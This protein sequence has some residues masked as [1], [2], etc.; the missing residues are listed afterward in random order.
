L[1]YIYTTVTSTSHFVIAYYNCI[2]GLLL[3][4]GSMHYGN[5]VES[6][7]IVQSYCTT[8]QV[9]HMRTYQVN[10]GA[11]STPIAL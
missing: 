5:T 2:M 4:Q 6:Q 11:I 8:I 1:C 3:A 7:L 9:N 10:H